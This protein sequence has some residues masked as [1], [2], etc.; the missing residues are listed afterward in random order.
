[1]TEPQAPA[2]GLIGLL[3][4]T[5][6]WHWLI[7]LLVCA[8]VYWPNLGVEGLRSTEG[9]RA[10]PGWEA[11]ESGRWLPTTMFEAVYV[12]KPP[13]MP[14]AIAASSLIFGET[15]FA[16]RCPSALS[17]TAMALIAFVFASRW[18]GR[19]WGLAAGIAQALMPRL[20]SAGRTAE[21]EALL[22][23]GTQLAA[24]AL[25]HALVHR[26]KTVG[27]TA[28]LWAGIG[29]AGL[30]VAL[31]A[32][33]H[34]GLPVIAG[35]LVGACIAKRSAGLLK[36]PAAWGA[37]LLAGIA[38]APIA[39]V[40]LR[41]MRGE[42]AVSEDFSKFLWGGGEVAKWLIFPFAVWASGLPASLAVL[43]PWGPDARAECAGEPLDLRPRMFAV[44]R[45]LSLGFVIAVLIYMAAG[46]T[47]DR[48]AMPALVL[49][50]PLV[51]YVARGCAEFFTRVRSRIGRWM[52]LGSPLALPALLLAGAAVFIAVLEPR[53]AKSSARPA[54]IAL[55]RSI[56]SGGEIWADA[57]VNAK[58]ELLWYAARECA[59]GG[60]AIRPLW[61]PQ[62]IRAAIYPPDGVRLLLKDAEVERYRASRSTD[63]FDV[64][65]TGEAD[66]TPF[67]LLDPKGR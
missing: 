58:P 31:L 63:M 53:D 5:S 11:L 12:R 41:A 21:I 51:A 52:A 1:M 15:E 27:R 34:A 33:A 20:W 9:H 30:F 47:N 24:F 7:V 25:V 55:A 64:R 17:A 6:H 42:A 4:R 62:E 35:I 43:F 36:N 56:R 10:I 67:T 39:W 61:K 60:G 37:L 59:R 54:G 23:V 14:W 8:A 22:C 66:G 32:K 13:G 38:A 49:L 2:P 26:K 65:A 46:I 28:W 19:P 48:Y 16:A 29:A 57:W 40:Q 45:C 18:F 44:A 3:N 50:P